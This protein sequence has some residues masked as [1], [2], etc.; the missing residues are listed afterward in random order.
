MKKVTLPKHMK[1]Q[2]ELFAK[3]QTELMGLKK[4][5]SAYDKALK[6]AFYNFC[7]EAYS[8]SLTPSGQLGQN[9][10]S[11]P[12]Q[13]RFIQKS[14]NKIKD[15][16]GLSG[17]EKKRLQAQLEKVTTVLSQLYFWSWGYNVK[18][19]GRVKDKKGGRGSKT[20]TVTKTSYSDFEFTSGMTQDQ[21]IN[22]Y[23]NIYRRIYIASLFTLAISSILAI[24]FNEQGAD[25]INENLMPS[26]N[27]EILSDP[28]KLIKL[29]S[30]EDT[31]SEFVQR[32]MATH[33][34]G[35]IDL[36]S[37][38]PKKMKTVGKK[39][40]RKRKVASSEGQ[41]SL[42][43][44][45]ILPKKPEKGSLEDRK[46]KLFKLKRV[47]LNG[48]VE[49]A[50][51]L[52]EEKKVDVFVKDIKKTKPK[53]NQYEVILRD[54]EARL[55]YG[56]L[57][58]TDSWFENYV[59]F[60]TPYTKKFVAAGQANGLVD[61]GIDILPV[62]K[63]KKTGR[64]EI[65]SF[66]SEKLE[67]YEAAD[68]GENVSKFKSYLLGSFESL[69]RKVTGK[70]SLPSNYTDNKDKYS[71]K[72]LMR[73]AVFNKSD[74]LVLNSDESTT[75]DDDDAQWF[76][77]L[78]N[79]GKKMTLPFAHTFLFLQ[80]LANGKSKTITKDYFKYYY[81]V[82]ESLANQKGIYRLLPSSKTFLETFAESEANRLT[83]RKPTV[84]ELE[85]S[86]TQ[87]YL[88]Y[89][90]GHYGIE[91]YD[92][93]YKSLEALPSYTQNVLKKLSTHDY[94]RS[95]NLAL[96]RQLIKVKFAKIK[97]NPSFINKIVKENPN[98]RKYFQKIKRG[99]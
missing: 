69:Y 78:S 22:V 25:V 92:Q 35:T 95:Y 59:R 87:L 38:A 86:K 74:L 42:F 75:W 66:E 91:V 50:Q 71:V 65:T 3:I 72:E 33:T 34:A 73:L 5:T 94:I 89:M 96:P 70:K 76:N 58:M 64:E 12:V 77:A 47:S 30:S 93:S 39:K 28:K 8:H 15:R 67:V 85:A 49:L 61:I 14:V 6:D 48:V 4:G 29:L 46:Q 41:L 56:P 2:A 45:K 80:D 68:K 23:R 90:E 18:G 36:V 63:N 60:V 10:W 31:K 16:K 43:Q 1:P 40:T 9:P 62:R 26:L 54:S 19:K 83:T 88:H 97:A 7:Y 81:T 27:S 32:I 57:F 21:K 98:V 11:P 51:I 24:D 82:F 84:K 17:S 53:D 20:N 44:E 79:S 52:H 55:S 99:R 37:T 13:K